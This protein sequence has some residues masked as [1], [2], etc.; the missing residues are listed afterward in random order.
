[1]MK[2][3]A[4]KLLAA[5]VMTASVLASASSADAGGNGEALAKL[6]SVKECYAASLRLE[7]LEAKNSPEGVRVTGPASQWLRKVSLDEVNMA[8]N[9]HAGSIQARVTIDG[10]AYFAT[11]DGYAAALA[12]NAASRSAVDPYSGNRIDKA[13][14]AAYA[15]AS[16]RVMYFESEAS[17]ND[18]VGMASPETVYG[19]SAPR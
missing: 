4:G 13:S 6:Q 12:N 7:A 2:M 8:T 5:A 3:N 14:A 16:G 18:F 1:M 9:R 19:Y 15:D 17:Y 10:R 11:G